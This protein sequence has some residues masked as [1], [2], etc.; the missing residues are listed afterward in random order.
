MLP[1]FKTGTKYCGYT[2]YEKHLVDVLIVEQ[3]AQ[4]DALPL[5]ATFESTN[6]TDDVMVGAFL[7]S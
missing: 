2:W 5:V 3:A 6:L 7:W 1:N 4:G